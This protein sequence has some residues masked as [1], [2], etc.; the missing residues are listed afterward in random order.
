MYKFREKMLENERK[1]LIKNK[2]TNN[3]APRKFTNINKGNI[4]LKTCEKGN[5]PKET[6]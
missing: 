3:L 5:F 4:P 2:R 1:S 6:N